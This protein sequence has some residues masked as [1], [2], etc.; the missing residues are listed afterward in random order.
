M[1]EAAWNE[2]FPR[3]GDG[4]VADYME[5][6]RPAHFDAGGGRGHH[7]DA[8]SSVLAGGG[9]QGG[10]AIGPRYFSFMKSGISSPLGP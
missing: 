10:Q 7:A 6:G 5:F 9:L 8:F 4:L 3:R 2:F 1:L